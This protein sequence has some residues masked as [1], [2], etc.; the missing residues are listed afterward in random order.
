M[1]CAKK[2]RNETLN[3]RGS[4]LI[5]AASCWLG[6]VILASI[7]FVFSYFFLNTRDTL[8]NLVPAEADIYIHTQGEQTDFVTRIFP[9]LEKLRPA[10]AA[11]F[12]Q[13]IDEKM[14]WVILLRWS[15]VKNISAAERS[16]LE[17]VQA[18]QLTE[19]VYLLGDNEQL[20]LTKEASL[21]KNKMI[22]RALNTMKGLART[23]AYL[24][25][26]ADHEETSASYVLAV[27]R[28]L[29]TS[30][31][32]ILALDTISA[33]AI[34]SLKLPN[35]KNNEN[36]LVLL[37]PP[38]EVESSRLFSL[39]NPTI[40]LI[41]VLMREANW[42]QKDQYVPESDELSIPEKKLEDLINKK[43]SLTVADRKNN[44]QRLRFS[45]Y[46]PDVKIEELSSTITNWFDAIFPETSI[47]QR[48][49][50]IKEKEY[51]ITTG[52]H[53]YTH[54]SQSEIQYL[55]SLKNGDLSYPIKPVG[56]GVLL[57]SDATMLLAAEDSLLSKKNNEPKNCILEAENTISLKDSQILDEKLLFLSLFFNKKQLSNIIIQQVGDKITIFCG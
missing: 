39:K 14:R 32:R 56:S 16:I 17:Q 51:I 27:N 57:A 53:I 8:A 10:E 45:L 36:D 1:V 20:A 24:K 21:A 42:Q 55:I 54:V 38:Q 49:D 47:F 30:K 5:A 15:R 29:N 25:L 22:S 50:G 46:L 43:V 3:L 6:L 52:R 35:A 19:R 33:G 13:H 44:D 12:A 40:N 34:S 18:Q 28:Q 26:T 11:A 9:A 23:Q 37:T 4:G 31:T 2:I 7:I 41:R 48:P